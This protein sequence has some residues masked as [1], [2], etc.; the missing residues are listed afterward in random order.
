[1]GK[2]DERNSGSTKEAES[3]PHTTD[4]LFPRMRLVKYI[5]L[6]NRNHD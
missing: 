3:Y 2:W 6:Y 5:Y 1:M 4:C